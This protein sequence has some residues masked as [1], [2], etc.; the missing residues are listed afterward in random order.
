MNQIDNVEVNDIDKLV[1]N[2]ITEDDRCHVQ[3]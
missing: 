2:N 1:Y 3:K